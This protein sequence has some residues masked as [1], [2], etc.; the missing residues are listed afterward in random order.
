VAHESTHAAATIID[1][2]NDPHTPWQ[3]GEPFAYMVGWI[4]RWVWDN[5]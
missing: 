2:T 3:L 4:A 1:T 5:L